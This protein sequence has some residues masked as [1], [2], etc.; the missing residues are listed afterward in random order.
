MEEAKTP[1]TRC[2]MVLGKEK[3]ARRRQL[4]SPVAPVRLHLCC[5][6]YPL[7]F[8]LRVLFCWWND[9]QQSIGKVAACT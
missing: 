1:G 2:P 8:P 9:D 5:G 7:S 3:M 4:M 6:W